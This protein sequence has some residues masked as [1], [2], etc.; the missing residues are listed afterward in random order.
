MGLYE[1]D[2]HY[3]L[4]NYLARKTGCFTD[5]QANEIAEGDQGTDEDPDTLPGAG[6]VAQNTVFHALHKGAVPGVGS[7]TLWD[8]ST[9]PTPSL[10]NFGRNLHYLQDTF[11]HE[12]FSDPA[13]GHGPLGKKYDSPFDIGTHSYDK[14]ASD[15]FKTINMAY[16]TWKAMKQQAL[17]NCNCKGNDWDNNWFDQIR[18][19]ANVKVAHPAA[20]DIEG[21]IAFG[22]KF[23]GIL[24]SPWAIKIKADILGVPMR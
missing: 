12:G 8:N 11:S 18:Q 4:T 19:F 21:E 10:K 14:T 3:Y 6:R 20:A 7:Q 5:A 23:G 17:Q 1:I 13:N 22:I 24:G 2:V 16:S 15:P 9:K